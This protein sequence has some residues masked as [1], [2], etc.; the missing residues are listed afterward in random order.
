M[1]GVGWG[2]VGWIFL[3]R[4]MCYNI[5]F[6]AKVPQESEESQLSEQQKRVKSY[7]MSLLCSKN[8]FEDEKLIPFSWK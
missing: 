8:P 5:L 3:E 6:G 1:G 7:C 4:S 2:G